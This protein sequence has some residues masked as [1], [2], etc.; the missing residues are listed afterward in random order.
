[1]KEKNKSAI[2][3]FGDR[4]T[5]YIP[6]EMTL[7]EAIEWYNKEYEEI[8]ILNIEEVD[9]SK[10]FWDID[11]PKERLEK[12]GDWYNGDQWGLDKNGKVQEGTIEAIQGDL[13]IFKTFATA[14]KENDELGSDIF[15]LC[16]ECF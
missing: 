10:G 9:Y 11:I 6:K 12:I 3:S 1:M 4:D 16:S 13:Y 8:D 5:V 2:Y 7:R 14:L 15:I